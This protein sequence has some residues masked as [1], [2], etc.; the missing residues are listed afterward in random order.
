MSDLYLL[1]ELADQIVPP[2]LE[3]LRE[4]ARARDRR[5][6]MVVTIGATLA[7]A[8]LAG[9]S[10]LLGLG[11]D[12]AAPLPTEQTG[13]VGDGTRPLTWAEGNTIHFGTYV[14]EAEGRVVELDLTDDGVTFRTG[15][16]RIW[17]TDGATSTEVGDLGD[18]GPAYG[19]DVWPI[20]WPA[21]WMVS[22]NT[23][24]RVAWFEFTDE[25][26]PEVVVFDTSTRQEVAREPTGI[27]AGHQ[28]ILY[29]VYDDA[30]YWLRDPRE[31][32]FDSQRL[33]NVR[34]DL[35]SRSRIDLTVVDYLEQVAAR[36][37]QRILLL[38]RDD[39]PHVDQ[40]LDHDTYNWR[41][42]A[43]RVQ[44]VIP[45]PPLRLRDAASGEGLDFQAPDGYPR[46]GVIWMSQW[47]DDDTIAMLA[48]RPGAEDLFVCDIGGACRVE[49]TRPT[50]SMV[51]PEF[52]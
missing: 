43:G 14:V 35:A 50:D 48:G 37:S 22:G 31:E 41:T 34:L 20:G 11:R 24:S 51:I 7:V 19:D 28:A 23:G 39:E 27:A 9:M 29:S 1:R 47:L 30:V 4:T 42:R 12:T 10:L 44:P 40:A 46:V 17:F 32:N 6:T 49:V 15:D 3:A 2:P 18:P 45:Q 26:I 25:Q 13:W 38:R 36:G 33:P 21:S 5:T 8:V 16:G 52:G